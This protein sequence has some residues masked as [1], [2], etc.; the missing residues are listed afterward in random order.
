VSPLPKRSSSQADL[1]SST[2]SLRTQVI[3]PRKDFDGLF[4]GF[5]KMRAV[6]YVI[7]PDLLLD[8]YDKR[9][10]ADLEVV[11]GENLTESY[12]QGLEQSNIEVTE[13]LAGLVEK[14]V[15]RVFVPTHTIHT[16][17]YIL[18]RAD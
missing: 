14:G 11:V 6:S 16:K 9:G 12:R 3:T 1:F 18:E 5:S 15:L 4:D 10:Y 2:R 7:S 8:F 13:R 17:L